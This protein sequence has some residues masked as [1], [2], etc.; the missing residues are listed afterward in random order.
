MKTKCLALSVVLA[1]ITL[2]VFM[3]CLEAI[4]VRSAPGQTLHTNKPVARPT[5]PRMW[6]D[7]EMPTLEVPLANPIGSPKPV[8]ADYY[9]KIPVRSI[10]KQY[11]VYA[12]GHEPAG[13]MEWLKKQ[14]PVILWD[15]TSHKPKLDTEADFIKAGELVLD[16][17]II[18]STDNKGGFTME[19]LRN[20]AWYA[21]NNMPLTPD[22]ILPFTHYVIREKGKVELG[23]FSCGMCHTRVMP[24][25]KIVKGAQGNFPFGG[26]LAQATPIPWPFWQ[27]LMSVPWMHP[28]PLDR[29]KALSTEEVVSLLASEPP[30]VMARH[31]GSLFEPMQVPDLI[32]VQ[33]RH[34]LDRTGLQQ[35]HSIVDL[36]RYA[37]L[38]Q[39]ADAVSSFDGFIPA[40]VPNFKKL[41]DPAD[42][43][44]V[45]G[46][47]SDE[48]LY[49]LALYIYSL[50]PPSNPNKFDESAARGKQVFANQGCNRCHTA[51]LYTNNKLTPATGFTV[52]EGALA[53]YDISPISVG[54]DPSLT[55]NTRRGTGY[56]KVPSLKGVWYRSMFGHS[57]WSATLEDWFIQNGSTTTTSP[58]VS[59][60][61]EPKPT[62]SK[63]TISASTSLHRRREI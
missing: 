62:P 9:Y 16:A 46:R 37:A 12:P 24:G 8:S 58:P 1:A 49:A 4:A 53:K 47:Y 55:M 43:M 21:K 14:V 11:P 52:P 31:R 3:V 18:Y 40:D 57:G 26:A 13:Y 33:D 2:T 50:K 15:E 25:G 51:P 56:Y 42:P 36:M 60:P 6:D 44:A 19:D 10:Y 54:T 38:N 59:N 7:A 48:Q 39:G 22:G 41:P 32:G 30:G 23:S 20:P 27:S 29:Q 35:Q 45:G 61:T 63:A 17:P 34:Y 5:I 28:D